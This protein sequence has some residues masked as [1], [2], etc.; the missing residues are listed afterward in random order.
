MKYF[1]ISLLFIF[2]CEYNPG[3]KEITGGH[4]CSE[5]QMIRVEKETLFCNQNANYTKN[6]CYDMAILRNCEKIKTKGEQGGDQRVKG[7]TEGRN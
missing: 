4:K 2:G 6:F 5:E 3:M 7:N 1:L